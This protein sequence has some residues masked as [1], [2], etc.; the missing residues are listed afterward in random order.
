MTLFIRGNEL[1]PYLIILE[2]RPYSVP[3]N[4]ALYDNINSGPGARLGPG[5]HLSIKAISPSAIQSNLQGVCI[6]GLMTRLLK[7]QKE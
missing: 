1:I 7:I 2:C 3:D 5:H 4:V 6:P